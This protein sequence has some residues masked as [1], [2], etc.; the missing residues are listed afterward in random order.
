MIET[1]T[2]NNTK[3][4]LIL[5]VSIF[6][7]FIIAMDPRS[8]GIAVH[9]WLSTAAFAALVT[10]LL[11]SWD[12]IVQTTRRIVSTM[13]AQTRFNYILNWLLFFDVTILM[14]SGFLISKSVMPFLGITLPQNFTWRALHDASANIFLLLLGIHTALHWNWI[15][16]ACTRYIFQP[17]ARLFSTNKKKDVAV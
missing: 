11:L 16:T 4:K 1:K 12:W 17:I 6:V 9:E 8:S 14:L 10:H 13:N 2:K 15:V 7:A 5:D 3:V